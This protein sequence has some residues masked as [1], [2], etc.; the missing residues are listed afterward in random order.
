LTAQV[1]GSGGHLGLLQIVSRSVYLSNSWGRFLSEARTLHDAHAPVG[2]SLPTYLEGFLLL[3]QRYTWSMP[4]AYYRNRPDVSLYDH[5]CM[6]AALAAVLAGGEL[7]DARLESL[8]RAPQDA[9]DP[10]ALLVGGDISGVQD[11]IYTITARG[12][13]SALRGRSFYLQLL[14]E[15]VTRYVLRELDLPISNLIYAS[16]GNFYLLARPGDQGR[17]TGIQR[18]VS[19]VLLAHHRG[20]L[21]VALASIPLLARDFFQ[22]RISRAWAELHR[23]QQRAKQRRFAELGGE[24]KALF[25]PQGHGGNEE[26]QCQVCGV[27]HPDTK[28]ER[29]AEAVEG[30]RKCLPCRSYEEL[31][32]DLRQAQLLALEEITPLPLSADGVPGG[33]REVL[34]A[35]GLRAAVKQNSQA[36]SE[37][38]QGRRLVPCACAQGRPDRVIVLALSDEALDAL[39]PGPRTAVG[40][41]FLVNVTPTI[42]MSEIARLKERRVERVPD[43]EGIKPFSAQEAQARG[44]HR[45]GLLR[46]DVDNLGRLFSGGLGGAGHPLA[47]GRVELCHQPVL[48]GMGRASGSKDQP[49]RSAGRP[50]RTSVLDLLRR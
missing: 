1:T 48:R 46:M 25:Q 17:L 49:G 33:W 16:G 37:A 44:I 29:E 6:T 45:L 30:V 18:N 13:T 14:T 23:E 31:G 36:L 27:E 38:G 24:L 26:A 47:C 34:A 40:R 19:R 4:A 21:Y 12:A 7:S 42:T 5:S 32:K 41:R 35:F 9:T 20:D 50:G 10:V 39:R 8:A 28:L 15:A 22:G 3:M 2:E 43:E 11:F